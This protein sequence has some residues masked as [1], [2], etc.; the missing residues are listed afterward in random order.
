MNTNTID[1]EVSAREV[2]EKGCT[3]DLPKV[4][5]VFIVEAANSYGRESNAGKMVN[6]FTLMV[7]LAG[8]F[9]ASHVKGGKYYA[10][11]I[12]TAAGVKSLPFYKT[13]DEARKGR[14]KV[15]KWGKE[16]AAKSSKKADSIK[17][18][19]IAALIKAGLT[20]EQAEAALAA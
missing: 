9:D 1:I 12:L 13:I 19:A 3:R 8:D 6:K 15:S 4:S 16:P 10:N 20:Q 11:E 5:K 17:A 18:K 14:D 7:V 2:A